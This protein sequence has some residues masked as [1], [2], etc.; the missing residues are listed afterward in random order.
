MQPECRSKSRRSVVGLFG[1][2]CI[3]SRRADSEELSRAYAAQDAVVEQIEPS[4]EAVHRNPVPA[5]IQGGNGFG[6][7]VRLHRTLDWIAGILSA[8][9][10][11]LGAAPV[12]LD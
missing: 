9:G 12:R 5:G 3:A 4:V 8:E 7:A 6:V 11:R 1:R 10:H 2:Y